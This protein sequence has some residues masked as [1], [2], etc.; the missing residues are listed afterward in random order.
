MDQNVYYEGS[1]IGE[2]VSFNLSSK[3]ILVMTT[4]AT[5]FTPRPITLHINKNVLLP[6]VKNSK[7]RKFSTIFVL[8]PAM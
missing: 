5:W 1:Q 4:Y 7:A 6:G 3:W 8:F 2:N